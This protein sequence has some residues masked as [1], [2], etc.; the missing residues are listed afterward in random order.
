MRTWGYPTSQCDRRSSAGAG[1]RKKPRQ[2]QTGKNGEGGRNAAIQYKTFA[3]CARALKERTAGTRIISF[4]K[5]DRPPDIGP[6]DGT[7]AQKRSP[8][9]RR[10]KASRV[11]VASQ[12]SRRAR[13]RTHTH[14]HTHTC[15]WANDNWATR[16]SP[17]DML[18]K[19]GTL[20]MEWSR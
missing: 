16:T 19:Q 10:P 18:N 2:I 6:M 7:P 1:L 14:T 13:A 12:P 8:Q 5:L 17:Y 20:C 9:M 11:H 4:G 15:A 3:L